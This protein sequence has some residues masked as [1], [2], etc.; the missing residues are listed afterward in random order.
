[1]IDSKIDIWLNDPKKDYL[2]NTKQA[3]KPRV[4]EFFEVTGVKEVHQVSQH[5]V[6]DYLSFIS[7]Q[8]INTQHTKT[9]A[10][11][12]FFSYMYETNNMRINVDGLFDETQVDRETKRHL[13]IEEINQIIKK[14]KKQNGK[15]YEII[16]TIYTEKLKASEAADR[17]GVTRQW[18]HQIIKNYHGVATPEMIKNSHEYH[19]EELAKEYLKTIA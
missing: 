7:S 1:M 2:Q 19:W 6:E 13:T 3:Y 8:S 4:K 15:H 18:I 9:K 5:H 16:R 17:F 12:S 10:V 14:A 11:K